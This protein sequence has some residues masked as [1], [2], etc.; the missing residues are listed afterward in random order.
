MIAL[1]LLI[2]FVTLLFV[3]IRP[4][5]LSI[6]TSALAGATL[7]MVFGVV[8][9][10]DVLTVVGIVWNATLTFVGMMIIS[11]VLDEI[12]FFEWAAL[13]MARWGKGSGFLLYGLMI[14]L[15]A[16]VA[17]FFANDGAALILTD[18]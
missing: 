7:A 13:N 17:A 16:F 4:W 5:N 15:G 18:P 2:F 10:A 9:W 3:L 12:G 11:L 1:A 6:G 8:S 14:V